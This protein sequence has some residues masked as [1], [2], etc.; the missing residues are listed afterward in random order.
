MFSL[1]YI[2]TCRKQQAWKYRRY[3]VFKWN[4][5]GS[6]G[7]NGGGEE[8]GG[9]TP[10]APTLFLQ[11]ASDVLQTLNLIYLLYIVCFNFLCTYDLYGPVRNVFDAGSFLG[12]KWHS[13][14]GSMPFQRAQ[15]TLHFQGPTPSHLPTECICAHQ[16]HYAQGRINHRCIGGFMNR[17]GPLCT[18]AALYAP[19]RFLLILNKF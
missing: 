19:H 16:N 15:K 4:I 8:G 7:K 1:L 18:G 13:P 11:K 3:V 17:S 2:K 5:Y 12:P 14:I 6:A 9:L 10:P